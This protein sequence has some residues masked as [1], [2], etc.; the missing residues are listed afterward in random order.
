MNALSPVKN[1]PRRPWRLL[2]GIWLILSLACSLPGIGAKTPTATPVNETQ[3]V[4]TPKELPNLPPALV[5]TNP[6][7]ASEI[8]LLAPLTLYFNQPMIRESVQAA[9]SFS[10][11]VEGVFEWLDDATMRFTPKNSLPVASEITLTVRKTA[12]AQNG[13]ALSQDE[14]VTYHT[15]S[16][17]KVTQQIPAPDSPEVNPATAVVVAF[18][19]PVVPLQAEDAGSG[20]AAFSL[21]PA[22][23]GK[24]SWLNTSTYIFHPATGLGGGTSYTVQM[25]TEL[26]S[27]DGLS[28]DAEQITN[29]GF[30]TSAPQVIAFNPSSNTRILLQQ[31]FSIEFNQPM[32]RASVEANLSL[33]SINGASYALD[34]TWENNDTKVV[35][36]PVDLLPRN[37]TVSFNLAAEAA[38]PGG[39]ALGQTLY[40]EYY[41]IPAFAVDFTS[42]AG[43]G[44]VDYYDGYIYV[45]MKFTSPLAD[46]S[47]VEFVTIQPDALHLTAYRSYD[48]WDIGISGFVQPD[49]TYTVSLSQDLKDIYGQ[50]LGVNYTWTFR[51]SAAQPGFNIP[52][53]QNGGYSVYL[54]PNEPVVTAQATNVGSIDISGGTLDLG[55]FIVNLG[56]YSDSL[57]SV[58][59]DNVRRWSQALNLEPNKSEYLNVPLTPNGGSLATGVYL[60]KVRAPELDTQNYQ[61]V[62][63]FLT[64]ISNVN[65][66]I[67]SNSKEIFVWVVD[68]RT[69]A[70]LANEEVTFYTPMAEVLGTA[71]T[72]ADGMAIFSIP[73]GGLYDSGGDVIAVTGRPGQ[74]DFGITRRYWSSG[75][76][77]WDFGIS[78][79]EQT[80]K[81]I[82]Y[83][84]TDRPI[85]RPGQEVFFRAVLRNISGWQYSAYEGETV[86]VKLTGEYDP[87]L[88]TTPELGQVTLDVSRFGTVSGV[89]TLPEDAQPGYYTLKI[90]ELDYDAVVGFKVANYRKPEFEFN[91]GFGANELQAGQ[92]IQAT[93][94]AKYYFGAPA[95]NL[96]VNWVLYSAR[97]WFNLPGGFQVGKIDNSWLRWDWMYSG[98]GSL[99]GSQVLTGSGRTDQKGQLLLDFDWQDLSQRFDA[100]SLSTLTLEVTGMDES[101][102]SI[103]GRGSVTLHP[104]DRYIGIRPESWGVQAGSEAGFAIQ[105]V[106]WNKNPIATQQ[107]TARFNSVRWVLTEA[108]S[109]YGYS[110]YEP[111]YTEISSTNF[112]T[113]QN[114]NARIAFTPPDPGTYMLE[115]RGSG[116]VSQ[117]YVWVGGAGTTE[118][119]NLPYQ[120]L[121][122]EAD[123]ESYTPGQTARVFIPNP[124]ENGALA[125]ITIEQDRVQRADVI[126]INGTSLLYEIPLIDADAPNVYITVTLIGRLA[127]GRVDFRMGIQELKVQ[128]SSHLLTVTLTANPDQA[129]PGDEITFSLLVKDRNGA[130]VQGE[131][132]LSVVDKAV[133]AL[134]DANASSIDQAFY[135]PKALGVFT[136]ISL[137]AYGRRVVPTPAGGRGGGGGGDMALTQSIERSNYKDTAYWTAL[138]ET[139][140]DGIAEVSFT[141]PDN[142]TTWV[143]TARGLTQDLRVG[144]TSIEVTTSK[145]LLLRPATP[146]FLVAGDQVELATVVQN[147][148]TSALNVDVSIQV[149]GLALDDP[150]LMIQQVNLPA[151]GR[152]RVAWRG[153]VQPVESVDVLFQ[154]TN[155]IY[156]D[157]ARPERNPIPVLRFSSPQT[158]GTS[159]V[160]AE[161]GEITEVISLPRSFTPTGGELRVEMAPSMAAMVLKGLDALEAYPY[162]YPEGIL[163]RLL[164]NLETYRTLTELGIDNPDLKARLEEAIT[165]GLAKLKAQQGKDGG[166][167]WYSN[168]RSDLYLTTY[169]VFGLNRARA[170]GVAVDEDM[171]SRGEN[172][173]ASQFYT[174]GLSADDWEIDRQVFVAFALG[175]SGREADMEGLYG[176]RDRLSPWSKA[177]LAMALQR[178]NP[179]D[180][181][182]QTLTSDL[183]GIAIRSATGAFW[184][185]DSETYYTL[186]TPNFNT[187]LVL[188]LLARVNPASPLVGDAVRYLSINRNIHGGWLSSY[189]TAWVLM[190]L[191]EVLRGTGELQAVY[192]FS[193]SV[194]GTQVASGT[195]GGLQNINIVSARLPLTNLTGDGPN[196]LTISRTGEAGRL[197]YRAF[198]QV[199]RSVQDATPINRGMTVE[200][201]Y[202]INWAECQQQGCTPTQTYSLS[203]EDQP[204]MVRMTVVVPNDLYQVVVEDYLPAGAEII[205]RSLKTSQQGEATPSGVDYNPYDPM[206]SG[207]G[208][209]WF[210]SPK[211]FDDH[212]QWV[213]EYLPSGTYT[214]TYEIMP[215]HVGEFQVIPAHAYM[216]YFPEVEGL[217]AGEVFSIM[218]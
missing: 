106:D 160:L 96:P 27:V 28:L 180:E 194:N 132:S 47:L 214:L 186:S 212:I 204:V 133:L 38:A 124:F 173:I 93:V 177:M 84:Y 151:G 51:V 41:T 91:I 11:A 171:F 21:E 55:M 72:D 23:D 174:P 208:W 64:A 17:L 31:E 203:A 144:E 19:R 125:L 25:N 164:P 110:S 78:N 32:D 16:A 202:Y 205:D 120:H 40:S 7:P 95:G 147:N 46:V 150:S 165:D 196:A 65:I 215:A 109:P 209:W 189:E 43:A 62:I 206:G 182:V 191:T 134:T 142:L 85:Y 137:S 67:K 103:S 66:T 45:N 79:Y 44:P 143:A 82:S 6:L 83:L 53:I 49:S 29:W 59:P 166:W 5:E 145:E 123:A 187:A 54:E 131:F 71:V 113:D 57:V 169:V 157:A 52:V 197:Y 8:G 114:G 129:G 116:A 35:F 135:A 193:A 94:E 178:V 22:V 195:A 158:Y 42:P 68:Y 201:Q 153:V 148:T 119:P 104:A 97:D 111:E 200:R 87:V 3:P 152:Q 146:R 161:P 26:V 183:E 70:P 149:V 156:Q 192:D 50:K 18:N 13:I 61:H 167:G 159:G 170:A 58:E 128:P 48:G 81:A 162:E 73:A 4:A 130:P 117:V 185:D 80:D 100:E 184:Q 108:A 172:F 9:L 14:Q 188:T 76:N 34:V 107:L 136:G 30:S 181:R 102:F 105:T 118:W 140:A 89:F 190:S 90:D 210:N 86:T 121:R 2:I 176:L 69:Q 207:W 10:P 154:A 213:A 88:D 112:G 179:N 63:P 1:S 139:N 115:V 168:N 141:L 33:Q 175:E 77:G 99:Y 101:N 56:T 24:G 199:Y 92:N 36:S 98:G 138:F 75:L 198:L 127:D 74:Y 218:P 37:T 217:S 155:D 12:Q 216:K 126:E 211:V 20:P 15:P 122:L 39:T 60:F 163:S